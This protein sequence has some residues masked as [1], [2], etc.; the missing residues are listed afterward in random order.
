M[1]EAG[2][3]LREM[4]HLGVSPD[5]FTYNVVLDGY[6]R[7]GEAAQ[8][9]A[10]YQQLIDSGLDPDLD[11]FNCLLRGLARCV[12]SANPSSEMS[13]ADSDACIWMPKADGEKR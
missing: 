3:L 8:V 11:T 9:K 7:R 12:L 2:A 13:G 5:T 4:L 1:D 10:L 6:A